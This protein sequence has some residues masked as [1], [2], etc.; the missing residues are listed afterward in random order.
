MPT[1]AAQYS[2]REDQTK[3]IADST[4]KMASQ[5]VQQV[6]ETVDETLPETGK[7]TLQIS[8]PLQISNANIDVTSV[9]DG[10][11]NIVQ[12]ANYDI[13]AE[14]TSFPSFLIQG[15]TKAGDA[16]SLAGETIDCQLYMRASTS[17]PYVMTEPGQSAKVTFKAYDPTNKTVAASIERVGLITSEN[18]RISMDGGSIVAVISSGG[19]GS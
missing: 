19:P 9:G 15:N 2:A 11:S 10:R 4:K 3:S 12:I 6:E 17:A 14:P 1:P 13:G 16:A 8:P 7:A 5:A 18:E